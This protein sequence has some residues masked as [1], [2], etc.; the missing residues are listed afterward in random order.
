MEKWEIILASLFI[1]LIVGFICLI[2]GIGI[3]HIQEQEYRNIENTMTTRSTDSMY[4]CLGCPDNFMSFAK[5]MCSRG[6]G[7][8][9][10]TDGTNIL[11]CSEINKSEKK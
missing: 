4:G 11:E 2:T 10:V 8:E 9:T 6:L 1:F 3:S 7:A 5:D